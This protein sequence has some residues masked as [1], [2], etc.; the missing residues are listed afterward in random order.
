MLLFWSYFNQVKISREFPLSTICEQA[1][2][3][4]RNDPLFNFPSAQLKMSVG[5]PYKYSQRGLRVWGEISL[6]KPKKKEEKT[7]ELLQ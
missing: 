2:L 3:A 7:M 1:K 5:A 6:S 4:K